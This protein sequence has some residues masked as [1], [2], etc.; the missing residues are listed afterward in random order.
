VYTV[1][2]Y[3]GT[4]WLATLD[5]LSPAKRAWAGAGALTS[6]RGYCAAAAPGRDAL[7]VLGGGNGGEWFDTVERLD[8]AS[9]AWRR[10]APLSLRRGSLAAAAPPGGGAVFAFGGGF[11]DAAGA[12]L[13]VATSER[14]DAGTDAWSPLPPLSHERFCLGGATLGGALYAVGGF[15]G[16]MYLSSVERYDPREGGARWTLCAPMASKRGSLAVAAAADGRTL[17]AAGGFRG[18]AFLATVEVYEARMDAWRPAAA[19]GAPR[20]YGAAAAADGAVCVLGGLNG[21]EHALAVE[22]Y[23]ARR[24]AW[25]TFAGADAGAGAAAGGAG[26]AGVDV[27]ADVARKRAFVAAAV[28]EA[29]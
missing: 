12:T 11:T 29:P 6:A 24:D 9:R 16:K 4:A 20:A 8:L 14:Y 10:C 27:A 18:D 26:G 3:D 15:D 25:R 28:V 1:G 5:C 23:D 19:L 21:R 13:G 17:L 2:G 7:Y 22:V